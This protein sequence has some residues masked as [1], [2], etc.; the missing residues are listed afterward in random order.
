[1]F[2]SFKVTIQQ[3][4]G[5]PTRGAALLLLLVLAPA[6]AKTQQHSVR[7]RVINAKTNRPITDE[8]LNVALKVDQIGSVA[9]P[10]D[11][12]GIIVV[13]TKDATTIRVLANMYADCRPRSELYTDY[14][15]GT[16]RS[17]GLTTGNLCSGTSPKAKPGE[18]I[19][20]EIPKTY[21]PNY[22]K[23]PASSLPHSDQDLR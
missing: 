21:I 22:P 20:F 10:T 16:I 6:F 17:N 5:A 18:L 3:K 2:S 12:N 15:I 14:S 4:P 1:M 9:M 7:I 11:K 8:K 19:L 23:P 13:D